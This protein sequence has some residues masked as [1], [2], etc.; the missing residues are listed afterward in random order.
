MES[1]YP[2]LINSIVTIIGVWLAFLWN[3]SISRKHRNIIAVTQLVKD[4]YHDLNYVTLRIKSYRFVH[5]MEP[6]QCNWKTIMGYIS[7]PDSDQDKV[8]A[9]TAVN[10]T[11][12]FYMEVRSLIRENEVNIDMLRS[13]FGYN[14]TVY[15]NCIRKK[16]RDA[17]NNDSDKELFEQIDELLINAEPCNFDA[18]N[19]LNPE[20][21]I[22]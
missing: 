3:R 10:R 1:I 18:F 9:L 11:A 13:L 21:G 20:P 4:F 5:K 8:A 19:E 6:E 2:A 22:K 16:I 14:Y 7:S 12:A 15:W 17:S